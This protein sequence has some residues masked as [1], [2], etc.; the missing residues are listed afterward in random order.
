MQDQFP[1]GSHGPDTSPQS[2]I[3][4]HNLGSQSSHRLAS[5]GNLETSPQ[6]PGTQFPSHP[7]I[8]DHQLTL[9][10]LGALSSPPIS[11][12]SLSS[13]NPQMH[14]H[15]QMPNYS[16]RLEC[17]QRNNYA[18]TGSYYP[19][20]DYSTHNNPPV[21]CYPPA[22]GLPYEHH[23]PIYSG[24][25]CSASPYPSV[26]MAEK[27]PD[28]NA[29][30]PNTEL[31]NPPIAQY[32]PLNYRGIDTHLISSAQTQTNCPAGPPISLTSNTD[33]GEPDKDI[34]SP[35]M[36]HAILPQYPSAGLSLLPTGV[37]VTDNPEREIII[38]VMGVTGN[39]HKY[40]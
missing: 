34:Q 20:H 13:D 27:G 4:T 7:Q 29:P 39:T 36:P 21:Q 12:G 15:Q 5:D 23:P 40:S 25:Y 18:P 2:L 22:H 30:Q 10:N 26:G 28:L 19:T 17:R 35:L 8:S 1:E 14:N 32:P 38:A 6:R 3:V 31:R 16:P 11:A 33:Y 9:D 24:A 37:P